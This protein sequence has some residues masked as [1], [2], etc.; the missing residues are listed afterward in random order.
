MKTNSPGASA[1]V[2]NPIDPINN[3]FHLVT[4]MDLECH[5]YI[6][7]EAAEAMQALFAAIELLAENDDAIEI[8]GLA[9]HGKNLVGE[10]H[11]DIDVIRERAVKAGLVGYLE[12]ASHD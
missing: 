10:L 12:G 6:S 3:G 9:K 4:R 8:K 11:N 2:V 7:M 1:S 5:C